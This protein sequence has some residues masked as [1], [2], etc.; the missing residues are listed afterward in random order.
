MRT[1]K[2]KFIITF[3]IIICFTTFVFANLTSFIMDKLNVVIS[4]ID[5]YNMYIGFFV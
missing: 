1:R 4:N 5:I 3:I 2:L